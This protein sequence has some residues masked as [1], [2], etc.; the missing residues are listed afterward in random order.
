M[1]SLRGAWHCGN[2]PHVVEEYLASTIEQRSSN[3][4]TNL[5]Q[6]HSNTQ[7]R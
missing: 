5:S 6:K 1:T 2:K 7:L 3:K 4:T